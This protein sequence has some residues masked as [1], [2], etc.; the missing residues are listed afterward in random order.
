MVFP[1]GPVTDIEKNTVGTH[2]RSKATIQSI[3]G[4][5]KI[6]KIEEFAS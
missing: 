4:K 2:F 5:L 6:S 3:V 1:L